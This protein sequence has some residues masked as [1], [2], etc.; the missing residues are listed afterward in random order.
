M[1]NEEWR[2]DPAAYE[3]RQ[4]LAT[5][6]ADI[7]RWRHVNN[8]AA[9]G[10]HQEA[11]MHWLRQRVGP[12]AWYS[13]GVLLRPAVIATDFLGEGRYP[14]AIV[15]AALCTQ[16]DDQTLGMASALFQ[17]G[18][19]IGQQQTWL[20]GWCNGEPVPLPAAVR[21]GAA[22]AFAHPAT[23]TDPAVA[24]A[25]HGPLPWSLSLMSRFGDA[26]GDDVMGDLA[27]ARLMEQARVTALRRAAPAFHEGIVESGLGI[28][29]AHTTVRHLQ[30]RRVVPEF[31][32]R[33]GMVRVGSSSF[34]VRTALYR[35]DACIAVADSVLVIVDRKAMRA[36]SLPERSRDALLE[37]APSAG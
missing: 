37:V 21:Q 24:P 20:Q 27:V 5:R 18:A 22:G 23:A 13:D 6:Y 3:T 34:T 17:N 29:V 19:C 14:G 8:V 33:I 28:V 11:R 26:D 7:D 10:L 30:Y 16:A 25:E 4:E 9:S 2:R 1:R 12:D 15:A 32:A 36:A 31:D 35:R